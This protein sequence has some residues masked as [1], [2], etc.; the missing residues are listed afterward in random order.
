MCRSRKWGYFEAELTASVTYHSALTLVRSLFC[1]LIVIIII[2]TL[3][4]ILH[5]V[6]IYLFI[7]FTLKYLFLVT[8]LFNLNFKL[9]QTDYTLL[10]FTPGKPGKI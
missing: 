1:Y 9:V 4:F 8:H 6:I 3:L 7:S 5:F 10:R 2:F